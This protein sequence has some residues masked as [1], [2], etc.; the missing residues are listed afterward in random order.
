MGVNKVEYYGETLIDTTGTTVSEETLMEGE[1][2]I[3]AAGETITGNL[4]PVKYT[5]QTPT[6]AEQEQARKNINALGKEDLPE[7]INAALAQAKE[8]GEFKGDPGAPGE[9]GVPGDPGEPGSDGVGISSLKQT[10]TSAEDGGS[11]VWR[12]TLSNGQTSDFTVKNGSKG[13]PGANGVGISDVAQR[14]TSFEN[15]GEN[16]VGVW[17]TNGEYSEITIRNGGQGSQG[18]K[19]EPGDPG[20]SAYE[21]AQDGGF[22]GT[23]EDFT[24]LLIKQS[25]AYKTTEYDT[26]IWNGNRE[27]RVISEIND[28]Y[29]HVSYDTPTA[30]DFANGFSLEMSRKTGSWNPDTTTVTDIGN[31]VLRNSR[32]AFYVIPEDNTYTGYYLFPKKGIYFID[33]FNG[34]LTKSL[35]ITGYKFTETNL[36]DEF[37]PEHKH[38]WEDIGEVTNLSGSDTIT[39]DDFPYGVFH[40]VCDVVPKASEIKRGGEITYYANG[41]FKTADHGSGGD[42]TYEETTNVGMYIANAGVPY[43]LIAYVDNPQFGGLSF[44]GVAEKGVYFWQDSN[45][46][47]HSLTINEYS[48][49]PTTEI[50]PVPNK[51]LELVETVDFD[52][53]AW[54]GDTEGLYELKYGT[55]PNYYLVSEKMPATNLFDNAELKYSDGTAF[56]KDSMGGSHVAD[57]FGDGNAYEVL[58]HAIVVYSDF[59]KSYETEVSGVYATADFKKGVYFK[60]DGTNYVKSL[61]ITGYTEFGVEKVKEKYLPEN[62]GGGS[63]GVSSW[64]DLT[65]KPFYETTTGED[66]ITWDG[67]KTG[68]PN[69]SGMFYLKSSVVPTIEDLANGGTLVYQGGTETFTS[70]GIS[71][72][73]DTLL[74]IKV[75]SNSRA[76]IATCDNAVAANGSIIPDKGVYLLHSGASTQ[77]VSSFAINGF[78]FK[79]TEIK[80]IDPKFLPPVGVSSWNDLTDRPFG[81]TTTYGDTLTWDGNTDGLSNAMDMLYKVSD[82]IF[83]LDE[84]NGAKIIGAD[85]VEVTAIEDETLLALEDGL[86]TIGEQVWFVTETWAGVNL[87]GIIFPEAGIYFLGSESAFVSSLTIDGYG[88][89]VGTYVD[90]I[91]EKYLPPFI[92]CV[93]LLGGV[94]QVNGKKIG[95]LYK[96][97]ADLNADNPITAA[98][99]NK[100]VDTGALVRINGSVAIVTYSVLTA[101]SQQYPCCIALQFNNAEITYGESFD[102]I[103]TKC[104]LLTYHV[105]EYTG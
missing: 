95:R 94:T 41:E 48:G 62:T 104:T 3:N 96:T 92:D 40:K 29:V 74:M 84:L 76:V 69:V 82:Q 60:K 49:F 51:Y 45:V 21:Y 61:K 64:N 98:E 71:N 39:S 100:I 53:L 27:G 24:D 58:E 102:T 32:G 66:I 89:F 9:P 46:I 16:I 22:T 2:A 80:T 56:T 90:K 43:V 65:D 103:G 55:L 91:D 17:L 85:G 81:E 70:D 87:D 26:V 44:N 54:D 88:G 83:T 73:T 63:G 30:A 35:T 101:D 12:A 19:G 18:E 6:A 5:A 14:S 52:T 99:W 25:E 15:R 1:T 78:S 36:I 77:Y 31:G 20:K 13:S 4:R 75:G 79:E 28:D 38:S 33:A 7:A 72:I 67:N 37:L 11:N 23:E 8:S 59:Y 57:M 97:Y 68:L 10:T 47:V 93:N 105:A 50:L 42:W 86:Y 34:D